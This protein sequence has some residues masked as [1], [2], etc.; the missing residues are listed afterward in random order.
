MRSNTTKMMNYK[1]R[2]LWLDENTYNCIL[3]SSSQA[4]LTMQYHRMCC[5]EWPFP[6]PGTVWYRQAHPMLRLCLVLLM[7]KTNHCLCGA[8]C[9]SKCLLNTHS[10][11]THLSPSVLNHRI[12]DLFRL[13]KISEIIKSNLRLK[14]TLPTRPRH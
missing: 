3:L 7:L 11:A 8:P 13:D 10:C 6:W 9:I 14:T 4:S 12:T 1:D 5:L 2:H